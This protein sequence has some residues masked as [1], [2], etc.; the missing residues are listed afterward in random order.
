MAA[1]TAQR[2][3]RAAAAHKA[4]VTDR[5]DPEVFSA[6][7]LVHWFRERTERYPDAVAYRYQ[8]L[9]IWKE[10]TWREYQRSVAEV[11]LGL[12]EM[13]V[14]PGDRVA[15]M[16]EATPEWIVLDFATQSLGAIFYGIYVTTRPEDLRYLLEDGQPIVFMAEDQEYVDKLFDAEADEPLVRHVV[17]ADMRGMFQYSEP[18]L[19]S[20][21][22][23]RQRG[24]E[25]LAER[26]RSWHE[27][28][29]QRDADE[30]NRISYTSGTTGRPKGAMLSS[31]NLLWSCS[32]LYRSLGFLP[33]PADRTVAYMPP[34]SP[35]EVT[36][37]IVLPA[38]YGTVPHIPEDMATRAHAF[39]EIGPTLLLAFPRM[40]EIYASRAQVD[41]DTGR[42]LKR[43]AYEL[44]L[45]LARPAQEAT[46]AEA[47][48]GAAATV[49]NWLAYHL[50]FRHLL[51]KFGLRRLRFVI[52]GGAPVSPDILRLWNLWGVRVQEIY[53]M[54]EVGGLATVQM[55]GRPLP[56]VAGKPLY[57]MEIR[58]AD[59]GEILLRSPGVFRGY[60]RNEGATRDVVD[61]DGWLHTGDIGELRPDGNLKVVDR[62]SDLLETAD[63]RVVPASDIEHRLKRS[64]YIREA[65]LAGQGRLYLTALVEID[66]DAVSEWARAHRIL[67]TSFNSL[68]TSPA[69]QQL[70]EETFAAVNE[71]LETSGKPGVRAFRIL[72]KELDPEEG[73]EVTST[74]KV[75]RRQLA[76][77]FAD[78][79]D[80]MYA[81]GERRAGVAASAAVTPGEGQLP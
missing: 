30:I 74:N 8:D 4:P 15:M 70:I 31:R 50:V 27:L 48:P 72:P 23:L 34:A 26:P 39:V 11:A 66:V 6:R 63:G 43:R 17:V 38:L 78:L 42:R 52:T 9:G 37:S 49:G 55:D 3:E 32:A 57:G 79:I 56:G 19:R 18:R 28:V 16:G 41:I 40:W 53:G 36:Y 80:S 47:S 2:H 81:D 45:R 13:G 24:A 51:D 21:E 59:D 68:I 1:S 12:E 10:V 64:P 67:Y 62:R 46:W 58:L 5:A 25:L 60:W 77:K 73:D 75:R 29:D 33:E 61:E 69:I 22:A 65:M 14:G 7:P 76:N 54:T 44:A 35:A 71:E 20:F